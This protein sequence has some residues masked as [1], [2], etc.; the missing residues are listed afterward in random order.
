MGRSRRRKKKRGCLF[1]GCLGTSAIFT[2]A[3]GCLALLIYLYT[4]R[5]PIPIP[6][7][8]GTKIQAER[9]K[10]RI[11]LFEDAL[12]KNLAAE[13]SFTGDELNTI[14]NEYPEFGRYKKNIHL[15]IEEDFIKGK[16]NFT[17]DMFYSLTPW[18]NKGLWLNG[19]GTFDVSIEKGEFHVHMERLELEKRP[20][21]EFFMIQIREEN[22]AAQMPI[23]PKRKRRLSKIQNIEVK[24]GK[25]YI[26]SRGMP[27]SATRERYRSAGA[28]K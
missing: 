19:V 28:E 11:R 22:L 17:P 14:I 3:I 26:R 25:V 5:E 27:S 18:I 2:L 6:Q 15:F 12:D 9:V 8:Q 20:L 10:E 1:W 23:G 16:V 7:Y 21:P 4:G 13:V 24:N